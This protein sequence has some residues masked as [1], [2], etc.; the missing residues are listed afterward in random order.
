MYVVYPVYI[1]LLI[2][3]LFTKITDCIKKVQLLDK[4]KPEIDI[5]VSSVSMET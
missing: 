3:I 2:F 5:I 1:K 4:K